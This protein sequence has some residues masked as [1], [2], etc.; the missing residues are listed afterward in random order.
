MLYPIINSRNPRNA[1]DEWKRSFHADALYLAQSHNLSY[2]DVIPFHE[3]LCLWAGS[4]SSFEFDE[5][6]KCTFYN[7][8]RVVLTDVCDL[9]PAECYITFK[10][11]GKRDPSDSPDAITIFHTKVL[12]D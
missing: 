7:D 9:D 5:L 6:V 1:F 2:Y 10:A 11:K 4:G 8:F 3:I 12:V